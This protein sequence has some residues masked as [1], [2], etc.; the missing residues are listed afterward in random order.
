[1]KWKC[2]SLF[3]LC[4]K[5]FPLWAWAAMLPE[6]KEG[7]G[8]APSSI[9]DLAIK[10]A[11]WPAGYVR[12]VQVEKIATPKP[13]KSLVFHLLRRRRRRE[14]ERK[15]GMQLRG[16]QKGK[17]ERKGIFL[18]FLHPPPPLPFLRESRCKISKSPPETRESIENAQRWPKE[19]EGKFANCVFKGKSM[20]NRRQ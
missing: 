3:P 15:V 12:S 18:L 6:G 2:I 20:R 19:G 10:H 16:S 5:W 1:M 4:I 9:P 8:I 11:R 13:G 7:R 17:E 14:I